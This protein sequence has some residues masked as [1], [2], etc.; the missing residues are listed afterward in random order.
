[1]MGREESATD[2]FGDVSGS[3]ARGGAAGASGADGR[4]TTP[5]LGADLSEW[6]GRLL[7]ADAAHERSEGYWLRR[8][9]AEEGTFAGVLAD[10]AERRIPVV[11]HLGNGRRHRGVIRALGADFVLLGAGERDVLVRVDAIGAIRTLPHAPVTLG[12]R[13]VAGTLT[14]AEALA[15]MADDRPRLLLV[16]ADATEAVS[17]ELRAV[18]RDVLHLRV[19]GGG[20]TY[21]ALAS[22][23]EVSAAESG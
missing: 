15:A 5:Q 9:A 2:G 18:G 3:G 11:V 20:S 16:G 19:D 23:I 7:V 12:D 21:V 8:Q 17:G 4:T 14:L 6:V 13:P 1:M 22:V 10:L